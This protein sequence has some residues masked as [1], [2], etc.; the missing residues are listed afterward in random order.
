[1]TSNNYL[2]KDAQKCKITHTKNKE[3][4]QTSGSKLKKVRK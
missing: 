2:N 4:K 3:G 1:M